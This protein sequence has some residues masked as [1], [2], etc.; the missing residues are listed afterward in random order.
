MRFFEWT[1]GGGGADTIECSLD[2]GPFSERECIGQLA[3]TYHL[4]RARGERRPAT[5]SRCG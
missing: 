3:Q 2:L 4:R 5:P 1:I